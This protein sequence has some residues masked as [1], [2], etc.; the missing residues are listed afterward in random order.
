MKENIPFWNLE[1]ETFKAGASQ[2]NGYI[3]RSEH[4]HHHHEFMFNFSRIPTRHTASGK[5]RECDSP[6]ILYRA[7][8]TLHSSATLTTEKYRR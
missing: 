7:P 1:I 6:Y 3:M 8:Y 2:S 5:V 4:A